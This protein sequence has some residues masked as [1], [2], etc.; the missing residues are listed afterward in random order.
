MA[1]SP[2]RSPCSSVGVRALDA[3]R[4]GSAELVARHAIDFGYPAFTVDG[5]VSVA[6]I[7]TAVD[8]LP[9]RPSSWR[10]LRIYRRR[11]HR[12]TR[13]LTYR[14]FSDV[15]RYAL[16]TSSMFSTVACVTAERS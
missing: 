3:P 12:A 14:G 6:D 4:Y 16:V 1:A 8:E 10:G 5:M 13:F 9:A 7:L 15:L 11:R 2:L